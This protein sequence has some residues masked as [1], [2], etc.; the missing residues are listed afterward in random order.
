VRN[1]DKLAFGQYE[2]DTWYFSP[3]PLEEVKHID[4]LYVC[5]YCLKYMRKAKTYQNHLETG[6]KPCLQKKPPGEL[7]YFDRNPFNA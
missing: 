4:I 1:I 2:I 5:E 6:D 3:Y 7:V